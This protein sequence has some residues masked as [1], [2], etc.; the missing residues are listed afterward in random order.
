MFYEEINF[1]FLMSFIYAWQRNAM[2]YSM[3]VIIFPEIC[4]FA[5]ELLK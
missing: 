3:V 1:P 5:T 4:F 2:N